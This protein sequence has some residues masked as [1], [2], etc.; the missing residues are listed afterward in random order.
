MRAERSAKRRVHRDLLADVRRTDQIQ[1][2]T[3]VGRRNLETEQIEIRGLA[4]Q[5]TGQ[6][7]VVFVETLDDGQHFSA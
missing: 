6:I 7:P 5:L 1:A 2:E 4:H 3:A